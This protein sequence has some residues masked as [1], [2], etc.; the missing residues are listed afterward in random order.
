[1]NYIK[2]FIS[3]LIGGAAS[4]LLQW[5]VSSRKKYELEKEALL[6]LLRSDIIWR[7]R[8]LKAIGY[9]SIEDK[10]II[11]AEKDVYQKLGGDGFVDELVPI[12]LKLPEEQLKKE[13][14]NETL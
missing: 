4:Y 12:I 13:E 3:A 11:G 10:T 7:C 9:A 6:C 14:K 5:L 2:I 1:M 8:S